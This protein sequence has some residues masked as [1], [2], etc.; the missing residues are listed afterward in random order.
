MGRPPAKDLTDRE[1]EVMHVFWRD[2]DSSANEARDLL[3]RDGIDLTYTTVANLVRA[4]HDK[5]FLVPINSDRP[6]RYRPARS[7][8]DVSRRLLGDLVQRVFHG[9][10]AEL[11]KQLVQQN[12]LSAEERT[13]LERVLKE[14]GR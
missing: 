1:L 4:L 6:F 13:L 12:K 11:L 7:R 8:E 14:Q 10:R 3:A 5:G 2:H 9:S